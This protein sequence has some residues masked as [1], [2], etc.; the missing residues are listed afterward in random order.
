ML[1]NIK[2]MMHKCE[3]PGPDFI[4][5]SISGCML[6]SHSLCPPRLISLPTNV[7]QILI[8]FFTFCFQT[9]PSTANTTIHNML[10]K[11]S[12]KAMRRST[13]LNMAMVAMAITDKVVHLIS[14]SQLTSKSESVSKSNSLILQMILLLVS[15][16]LTG[17][18]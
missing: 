6:F 18:F 1:C 14:F 4:H 3:Q 15:I 7:V 9:T 16:I 17:K 12:M 8:V 10:I 13:G 11:S 2:F 5:A